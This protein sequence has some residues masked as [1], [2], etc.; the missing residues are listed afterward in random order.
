[1]IINVI[2]CYKMIIE[3]ILIKNFLV[4]KLKKFFLLFKDITIFT[5]VL[6]LNQNYIKYINKINKNI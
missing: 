2:K 1:M 4:Y 5:F 3:I 6:I